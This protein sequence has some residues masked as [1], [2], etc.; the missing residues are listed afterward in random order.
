M[1]QGADLFDCS[2]PTHATAN[3]CALCFPLTRQAEKQ[4]QQHAE[5]QQDVAGAV[6]AGLGADDSKINLWSLEYR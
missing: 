2:F 5:Q 3:G 1:A 6:D 4:Q